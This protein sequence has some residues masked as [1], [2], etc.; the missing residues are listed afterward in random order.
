MKSEWGAKHECPSCGAHFYDMRKPKSFCPKCESP[1]NDE[2]ALNAR[3]NQE[4][5]V[6]IPKKADELEELRKLEE[7]STGLEQADTPD[8]VIEDTDDLVGDDQSDMSEVM[9]HIDDGVQDQN[10]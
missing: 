4:A 7:R 9:E 8:D 5:L 6:V 10:A 1:A 2:A 3:I